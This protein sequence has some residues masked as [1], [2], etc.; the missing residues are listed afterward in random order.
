MRAGTK[1]KRPQDGNR[2]SITDPFVS[3]EVE[4]RRVHA[5]A[6]R[7]RS[8]RT[9]EGVAGESRIASGG[10][11]VQAGGMQPAILLAI[12]AAALGGALTAL[13]APTNA[14]LARAAGSPVNAALISFSVGTV[15]LLALALALGVRPQAG[16]LRELPAYVWFGGLYGAFFVTVA[17]FAVPKLG[18]ASLITIM[19]AGQLAMAVAIDHFGAFGLARQEVSLSRFVGILLVVAGVVL[20]RR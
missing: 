3:S 15:A 7:L 5:N 8:K 9:G 6:S 11:L 4:K 16:A 10:P 20:V 19:V 14:L 12:A 1:A 2:P 17:A 18:V 13:Q